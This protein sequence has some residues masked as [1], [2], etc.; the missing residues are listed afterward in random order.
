MVGV[1]STVFRTET[2]LEMNVGNIRSRSFSLRLQIAL[3]VLN[4]MFD[5]CAVFIGEPLESQ[6]SL[7]T[8]N[9]CHPHAKVDNPLPQFGRKPTFK[10]KV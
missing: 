7:K 9:P 10:P 3:R 1:W 6:S 5:D 2:K 4:K 8:I